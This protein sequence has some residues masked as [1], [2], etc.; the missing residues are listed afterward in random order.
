MMWKLASWNIEGRLSP[1]ATVGRGTPDHIAGGIQRLQA[2]V[3][4]LTES[5][6]GQH[7]S[8]HVIDW[9][10]TMGYAVHSVAYNDS[11]PRQ[12][13]AVSE[14]AMTLLSR[15]P[16]KNI[17][18]TRYGGIRTL[19]RADVI[20]PVSGAVV[21]LFCI[22]LDDRSEANRLRQAADLIADVKNCPYPFVLA[23]DFNAM[24][25][26]DNR[27]QILRTRAAK[28]A[29]GCLRPAKL[30]DTLARLS[31]MAAGTTLALLMSRL[32]LDEAD[33]R[34]RATSTPKMRGQLILP[35]LRMVQLDHIFVSKG[36]FTKDF[37][38]AP[39]GGSD[40]RAITVMLDFGEAT[41]SSL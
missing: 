22:H 27:A 28:K 9:L 13:A 21:R 10:Q 12:Y 25:A 18:Q 14:P 33:T 32:E 38:V 6:D 35:S 40:H 3:I 37:I 7:V 36:V 20:E 23:G 29:I 26:G 5:H 31:E 19:L 11:G 24:A 39:D 2:D 8:D 1:Y 16:L 15:L 41:Q 34:R 30:R 17:F 4:V